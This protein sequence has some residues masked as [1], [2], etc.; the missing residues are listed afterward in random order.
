MPR[1]LPSVPGCSDPL[2]RQALLD[3]VI[4]FCEETQIVRVT[5]DPTYLTGGAS[6]YTVDVPSGQR[7]VLTQRAWYGTTELA[8]M[9]ASM[10][11]SVSVFTGSDP[12]DAAQF[13][14][15]FLESAPGEVGL[16]PTPGPLAN[17]L[18]T[19]RVATKPSRSASSVENVLFE[20]WS[21]AV[22]AGALMRLHAIPD[23][24]FF[25]DG[26]A[27]RRAAQFQLAISRARS[28]A[29]RGRVRG[30]LTVATR[31]FT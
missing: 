28:E 13:P 25:S 19:F 16:Y 17:E 14:R 26:H 21:E 4:E 6:V 9:P 18:L 31:A 30:S 7:V 29:Q 10:I 24:P 20:D 12:A 1:L 23:T 11:G 5:T 15:Y 2:A 8:P 3:A 27:M 22:V